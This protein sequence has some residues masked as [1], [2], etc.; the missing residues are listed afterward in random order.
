ME[1]SAPDQQV[2]S[3][4]VSL[5]RGVLFGTLALMIAL[6][7]ADLAL[8]AHNRLLSQQLSLRYNDM[9]VKVGTPLPALKGLSF[10]KK[11]TLV[12]PRASGRDLAVFIFSPACP[13]CARN[14]VNW[15]S[16]IEATDSRNLEM[17]FVDLSG[18]ATP[19][20]IREHNLSRFTVINAVD[21]GLLNPYG[22]RFVPETLLIDRDRVV[23]G[24]WLGELTPKAMA[25]ILKGHRKA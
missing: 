16:L 13:F 4:F 14:W 10:D 7:G 11:E 19:E 6:L 17:V 21:P 22:L 25:D 1:A 18:S 24:S 23:R 8:L 2:N 15:Q 12:D 3:R 9:T 5:H 20:F